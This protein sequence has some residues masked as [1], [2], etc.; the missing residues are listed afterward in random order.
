MQKSCNLDQ[1]IALAKNHKR[2]VLYQELVA[3]QLTPIS[4]FLALQN[5]MKFPTLLESAEKRS[6]T[7]RYSFL[8]FDPIA[9]FIVKNKDIS[10]REGNTIESFH[11]EP[12]SALRE[13]LKR[14]QCVNTYHNLGFAGGAV[15]F[16]AYDAI[17]YFENIP[18][19]HPDIYKM[20]DIILSFY[21]TC[22]I[23]DH[24]AEKLIITKVVDIQG[25]A[26]Q[27][28]E[29]TYIQ[30]KELI[31][32]INQPA[33][34]QEENAQKTAQNLSETKTDIE[35][36]EYRAIVAKAKEYIT[37][38]DAFQIVPSRCFVKPYSVSP[39]TIYRALRRTSPAPYMFYL[40]K[41]DYFVVGASPEKLV[42]V[43]DRIA[44][45]NPIAGTRPRG[46]G[47][48]DEIQEAE[49][50]ASKKDLAEHV[51]L[52]D[53][54]R[55]DIG[56]VCKPGTVEV[57]EFAQLKK[58]SHVMHLISVVKG[59]LDDQYDALDALR[60]VLPAG[61]L[62]GAPKIRAMEIIDELE[63]SRRGLYGGAICSIDNVGNLDSCIAIR[64]AV[65]R[66][67]IATVR[68]GGGVV[69]DSD[70]QAEADET[71]QKAKTVLDA[72]DFAEGKIA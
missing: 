68:A 36:P 58:Y 32:M 47:I 55:N 23:F 3:D 39:F 72:L 7:G 60:A 50:K 41:G 44:I 52:V 57:A 25:D 53:L 15:G 42:S 14:F 11:V 9:E 22:I 37:R 10:L 62:S 6:D 45:T 27:L 34:M 59:E 71:R 28:Y 1:F 4:V 29:E 13:V 26:Q 43:Q 21:R 67:G 46:H 24:Q 49:L 16:I 30:I 8:G 66:D 17:R 18:D 54:G 63:N 20:P 69:F 64:M 19:R 51:M 5:T 33:Y 38:G 2:V 12:I 70:L 31:D 48:S 56:S 61:T 65:L 40:D 35:D